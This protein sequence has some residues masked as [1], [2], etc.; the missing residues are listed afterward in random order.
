MNGAVIFAQNNARV[1]Y[2]KLA[3]FAANQIKKYLNIPVSIITDSR[4][5]LE[6]AYPDHP[7]DQIIDIESKSE[8]Q[9][10]KF[11]DGSLYG[12]NIEWKNKERTSIYQLTPYDKTLVIDSDYIINSD[13]L[14]S[15]FDNN[16][17]LQIYRNGMDLA[18]WRDTSEFNR[19]NSYTI[20]F[21]WATVFV[22]QKNIVME[23]F[24]ILVDY[25]K[26]NWDYFKLLYNIRSDTYRNDFSFSIAIHLLNGKQ[27]N[28]FAVELPGKMTYILDKDFLVSAKDNVMNF[29]VEKEKYLGEYTLVKTTGLDVHVMNKSSLNRYI[30]GGS[31]V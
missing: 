5:W 20:P 10:K 1:D 3:V 29:L 23:S 24:F 26:T 7:F 21:Y 15:V 18:G 2:V 27:E 17:D 8:Q 16:Y 28:D 19:I 22:F 4:G 30:D 13:I 12:T 25:I 14:K 9:L 31:G 11:N 6:Q